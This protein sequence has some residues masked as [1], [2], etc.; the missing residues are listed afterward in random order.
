MTVEFSVDLGSSLHWEKPNV[1]C[2][3]QITE[4][5]QLKIYSAEVQSRFVHVKSYSSAVGGEWL[6][7]RPGRF[8]SKNASVFIE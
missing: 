1:F 6:A 5:F 4:V 2:V 8:V 3:R 7:S